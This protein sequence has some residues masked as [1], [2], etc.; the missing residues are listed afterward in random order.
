MIQSPIYQV[1]ERCCCLEISPLK[2]LHSEM[3]LW[4]SQLACGTSPRVV[5]LWINGLCDTK[6]DVKKR[7]ECMRL[8]NIIRKLRMVCSLH[9]LKRFWK[10]RSFCCKGGIFKL[11]VGFW[12]PKSDHN[13]LEPVEIAKF[14]W[15]VPIFAN[16]PPRNVLL[17]F[18]LNFR[19]VILPFTVRVS[20]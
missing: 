19:K 1:R 8:Q 17:N 5:N 16:V 15:F 2:R 18:G 11:H 6:C 13:R 9:S 14:C 4:M 12:T 7:S 3:G 20:P 10:Y